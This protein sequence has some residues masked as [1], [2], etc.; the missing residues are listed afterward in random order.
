[1]APPNAGRE[2]PDKRSGPAATPDRPISTPATSVES[3]HGAADFDP[4]AADVARREAERPEPGKPAL[5]YD[6]LL[7]SVLCVECGRY[8]S[9]HPSRLCYNCRQLRERP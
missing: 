3:L 8:R 6:P 7:S 1:M 2:P 5:T 9:L 4:W